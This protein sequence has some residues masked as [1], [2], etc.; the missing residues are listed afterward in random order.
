MGFSVNKGT[1]LVTLKWEDK[2]QFEEYVLN[3]KTTGI[4][5]EGSF[6][7]QPIKMSLETPEDIKKIGEEQ[8]KFFVDEIIDIL[9]NF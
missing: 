8:A 5:L 4:S 9:K 3:G 6:L 1:W 7:S 2:K